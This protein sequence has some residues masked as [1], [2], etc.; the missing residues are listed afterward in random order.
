MKHKPFYL[1]LFLVLILSSDLACGQGSLGAM[2]KKA[3]TL[4]DYKHRTLIEIAAAGSDV[5]S[6]RDREDKDTTVVSGDILPSR[7]RVTYKGFVRPLPQSKKDVIL[8]WARQY[9]GDPAHYTV[10]YETEMLF[11]EDGVDHWLTVKKSSLPH[12]KEE[13]KEGEA[14]DLYVIRLGGIKSSDKW[15]WVL[16]VETF[17]KPK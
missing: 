8:R 6:P 7:V 15:G 13:L 12:F 16:L 3:R 4:D 17:V 9:A 10:P 14:V 2:P 5:V 1:V 11:I